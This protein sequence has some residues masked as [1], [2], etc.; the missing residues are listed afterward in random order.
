MRGARLKYQVQ[1]DGMDADEWITAYDIAD[2]VEAFRLA[3]QLSR[4]ESPKDPVR[5]IKRRMVAMFFAGRQ[6]GGRR[7]LKAAH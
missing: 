4:T 3:R 6:V 1:F 5:V 2:R 7:I